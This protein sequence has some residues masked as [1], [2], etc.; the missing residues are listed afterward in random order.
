MYEESVMAAAVTA[1]KKAAAARH[2]P[3]GYWIA[4]MLAGVYVGFG[5]ILIFAV[6]AGFANADHPALRLVMGASFGIALTLVIFAG[7]E[8]F[9]GNVMYLLIGV[10][11][12]QCSWGDLTRVWIYSWCGNLIGALLLAWVT[13]SSGVLEATASSDLVQKFFSAKGGATGGVLIGRALLCNILVCL[14]VWTSARTSSEAARL[15]LIWWCL[16]AFIG[17]GF[18]HSIANMTLLGMGVFDSASLMSSWAPFWHNMG[19][20]TLGNI[21]GGGLL[22]LAYHGTGAWS[23]ERKLAET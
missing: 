12:K 18:E 2:N 15:G 8:L 3:I 6:G 14:A 23:P 20:V 13:V 16:F 10:L 22:A 19:W 1:R 11:R 21:F 17:P 5:I 7:S 9:T 4:S